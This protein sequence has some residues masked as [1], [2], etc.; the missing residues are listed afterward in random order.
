M[1]LKIVFLTNNDRERVERFNANIGAPFVCDA[2]KPDVKGYIKALEILGLEKH[3]A[4]VVGD[5]MFVDIV[6]ANRA[7]AVPL[8]GREGRQ[9]GVL[10]QA[11]QGGE[12]RH[13]SRCGLRQGR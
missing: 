1:G 8:G 10:R 5:Q 6:G 12:C 9:L 3:E 4:V 7:L 11:P 2:E 13:D